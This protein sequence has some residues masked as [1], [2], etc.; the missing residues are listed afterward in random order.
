MKMGMTL[1]FSVLC[2]FA[3]SV[4][5]SAAPHVENRGAKPDEVGYRPGDGAVAVLNPPSLVWLHQP[6][7][8]TYEVQWA[9]QEDFKDA[10]VAAG[11]RWNTYTHHAPLAPG[12]YHWR[13]RFRTKEGAISDWS[14][15]RTFTVPPDAVPFPMPTRAQQRERVTQGRP[16][17]FMRPEDLPRLRELATGR[18]AERFRALRS[19][20]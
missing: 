17:L 4:A 1:F 14:V 10:E 16:R 8:E 6:E 7:A 9:H 3:L 15:T 2:L 13:Y 11:F 12:S 5:A 19:E 20:E 18:E